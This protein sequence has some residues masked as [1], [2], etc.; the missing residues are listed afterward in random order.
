MAVAGAHELSL[1]LSHIRPRNDTAH[2]P[3]FLHGDLP[4]DLAAPV[5]LLQAE[6]LLVA[7][8]LQHRVRRCIYDHVAGGDLFFCQLIQDLCTAGA[9]ISNDR[10][11]GP[12]LQ[13]F[14][15]LRRKS[16]ICK[17]LK[18]LGGMNA[19]HFPVAGHGVLSVAHLPHDHT[20]AQRLFLRCQPGKAAKVCDPQLP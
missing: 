8:D 6:G 7:A 16:R 3:F 12:F 4:G 20:V 10:P 11:A 19:H 15:K 9:L 5:K 13:F 17:G 1:F 14:Y 18:G 2:A